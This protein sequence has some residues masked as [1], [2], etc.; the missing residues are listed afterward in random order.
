MF[1]AVSSIRMS[2]TVVVGFQFAPYWRYESFSGM[3]SP[4]VYFFR[5]CSGELK[6]ISVREGGVGG[7]FSA[8]SD[9]VG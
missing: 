4:A 1:G 6:S 2:F 5:Y 7:W 3:R 9:R 8:V